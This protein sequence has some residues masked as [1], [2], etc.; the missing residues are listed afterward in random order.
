MENVKVPRNVQK[1]AKHVKL[2]EQEKNYIIC[3]QLSL[4]SNVKTFSVK[5]LLS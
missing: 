3:K 1:L 4:Q 2:F 5:Y